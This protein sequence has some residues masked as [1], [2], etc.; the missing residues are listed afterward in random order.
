MTNVN[1]WQ[2]DAEFFLEWE[3]FR[4]K[5]VEKIQNTHFLFNT[6]FS[7][8]SC[9]LWDNVEKYGRVRHATGDSII[10]HRKNALSMPDN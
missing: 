3:M 4:L 7:Q 8:K 2:Y 10:Q 6:F 9:R 5:V 1:L